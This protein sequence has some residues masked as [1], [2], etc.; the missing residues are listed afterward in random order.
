M[1]A[2]DDATHEC[3]GELF[4]P[5]EHHQAAHAKIKVLLNLIDEAKAIAY[6]F[7]DSP[8]GHDITLEAITDWLKQVR[9]IVGEK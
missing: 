4:V 8:Y 6:K 3:D 5:L 1:T 7:S 2:E 9:E